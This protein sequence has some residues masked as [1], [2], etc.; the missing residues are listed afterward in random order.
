MFSYWKNTPWQM[1]E[2][3]CRYCS[4][5]VVPS[6]RSGCLLNASVSICALDQTLSF[7]KGEDTPESTRAKSFALTPG[8][9]YIQGWCKTP[10]V[11]GVFMNF[12]QFF[13][14]ATTNQKK[15]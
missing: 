12:D 14:E 7:L 11:R 13:I 4:L 3:L 5:L 8:T 15:V 9:E 6:F 10:K 2:M 1:M